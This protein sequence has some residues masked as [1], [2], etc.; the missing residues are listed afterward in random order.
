VAAFAA[1]SGSSCHGQNGTGPATGRKNWL[2]RGSDEG[3]TRAAI[4][5]SLVATCKGHRIDP[6]A[7]LDDVLAR[8]PTHPDRRRA[9]LLPRNWPPTPAA[10]QP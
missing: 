2:F 5:Y 1:S 10:A 7:N 4:L 3:G 9:E 8:I 6:W